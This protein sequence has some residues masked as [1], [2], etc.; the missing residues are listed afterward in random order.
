MKPTIQWVAWVTFVPMAI[1]SVLQFALGI[2]E[3]LV[4]LGHSKFLLHQCGFVNP[5]SKIARFYEVNL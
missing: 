5:N 1:L 2:I 4:S 3:T